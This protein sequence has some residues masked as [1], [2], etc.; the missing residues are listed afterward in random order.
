MKI[1]I[2]TEAGGNIG[3]GHL[4]RCIALYQAIEEKGYSPELIVNGDESILDFI[5]I[6]NIRFL[7]G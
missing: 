7:T 3:F 2:L 5:K 1:T 4:T 6:K